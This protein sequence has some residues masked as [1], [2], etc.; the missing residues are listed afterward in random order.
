MI[1]I[2]RSRVL[3]LIGINRGGGQQ[4]ALIVEEG[5][6]VVLDAGNVLGHDRDPVGQVPGDEPPLIEFKQH[7]S[8]QD[9]DDH[10]QID[11]QDRRRGQLVTGT[12][13]RGQEPIKPALLD[14]SFS[15]VLSHEI[16]LL[17]KLVWERFGG[18][19]S[20]HCVENGEPEPSLKIWSLFVFNEYSPYTP[21]MLL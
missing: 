5:L 10:E 7:E 1:S 6:R 4:I 20:T 16:F 8:R 2:G 3:R 17:K 15:F 19:T 9:G 21:R 14:G 18:T 11:E 12:L 13:Q